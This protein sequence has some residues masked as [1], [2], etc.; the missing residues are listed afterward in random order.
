MILSGVVYS[1]GGGY[2]MPMSSP[3]PMDMEGYWSDVDGTDANL[4]LFRDGTFIA[5]N[6]RG[7]YVRVGSDSIS[8]SGKP[9]EVYQYKTSGITGKWGIDSGD[10][11]YQQPCL[12]LKPD[13]WSDKFTFD[14]YYDYSD[15]TKNGRWRICNFLNDPERLYVDAMAREYEE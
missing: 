14:I 4:R 9:W 5:N 7:L 11:P 12:V 13:G 3:V 8:I 10:P 2:Y 1:C 15:G 6:V